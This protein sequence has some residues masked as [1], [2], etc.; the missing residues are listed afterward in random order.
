[1]DGLGRASGAP[2]VIQ[3]GGSDYMMSALTLRDFGTIEQHLLTKRPNMLATVAEAVKDMPPEMAKMLMDKAYDD[4]KKGNTIPA[5]EVAE[6]V[7]T[8][9]GMVF[10]VWLALKKSTRI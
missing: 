5:T 3:L 4:M 9:E 2:V 1:M 6:W 10:S 7:D 8:F